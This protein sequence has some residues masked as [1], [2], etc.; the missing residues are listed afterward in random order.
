MTDLN[1]PWNVTAFLGADPCLLDSVRELRARILFDR[2]RR[3]AFRRAD[4]SHADDQDLD[5]GAWHF[6][7]RQRPDGPPLGYIRLSTPA[8]GDSF[9]SRTY[10][11]T[12]RYEELLAAQGID[13]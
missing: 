9:Q 3:P 1:P 5:F 8:T 4:G 11:G 12:E 6:V 7:A 2:G 13:P 10:L